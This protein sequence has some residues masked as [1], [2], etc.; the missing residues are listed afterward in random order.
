MEKQSWILAEIHRRGAS[1]IWC[2]SLNFSGQKSSISNS[3]FCGTA[4]PGHI[5][6]FTA[7]LSFGIHVVH[8]RFLVQQHVEC[9]TPGS[10]ISVITDDYTLLEL[11]TLRTSWF[12]ACDWS[13]ETTQKLE[14]VTSMWKNILCVDKINEVIKLPQLLNS[15]RNYI[16]T[17]ITENQIFISVYNINVCFIS[18]YNM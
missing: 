13:V 15:E 1:S 4:R 6:T 18:V 7:L 9:V 5:A 8:C 11:P 12:I 2:D 14:V 16:Q 3:Q 17:E 10:A